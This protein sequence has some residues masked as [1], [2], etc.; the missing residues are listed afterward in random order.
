MWCVDEVG[1]KGGGRDEK[2]QSVFFRAE[3]VNVM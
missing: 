2:Q 3:K 1:R